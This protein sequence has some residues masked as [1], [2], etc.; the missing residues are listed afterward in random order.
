MLVTL[1]TLSSIISFAQTRSYATSCGS[2]CYTVTA[3]A[4]NDQA[5]GGSYDYTYSVTNNSRQTL[6]IVMFVEKRNGEWKNLG[7][8][9]DMP[10]GKV[11]KDSFWSCDLSGRYILYYRISGSNDKFPTQSEINNKSR[12]Y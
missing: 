7:M 1:V 11:S 10:S 2:G 4:R 6:D 5:C 9:D 12:G 8:L 3:K